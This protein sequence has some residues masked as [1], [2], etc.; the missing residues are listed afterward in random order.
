MNSTILFTFI[1]SALLI[2]ATCS[3]QAKMRPAKEAVG[4]QVC[5][6]HMINYITLH[7]IKLLFYNRYIHTINDKVSKEEN[8]C[9][10]ST[11]F[12]VQGNL[13]WFG[14]NCLF[15]CSN[16]EARKFSVIKHSQLAKSMKIIKVSS[17][18]FFIQLTMYVYI[19]MC[20]YIRR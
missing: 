11:I 14:H 15:Q 12:I 20:T 4:V 9:S 7:L 17:W 13:L 6:F 3:I 1:L 2:Q 10:L 8:F 18:N 5:I 19:N 16:Y